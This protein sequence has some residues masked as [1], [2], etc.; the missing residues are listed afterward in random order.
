[1]RRLFYMCCILSLLRGV[2]SLYAQDR[3]TVPVTIIL[4]APENTGF[5]P[6]TAPP[7]LVVAPTKLIILTESNG[8]GGRAVFGVSLSTEPI[9][10][11]NVIFRITSPSGRGTN[12]LRVDNTAPLTFTRMDY[13]QRDVYL[14]AIEH[15]EVGDYIVELIPSGNEAMD[16]KNCYRHSEE[17]Y[18]RY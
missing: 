14:T 10:P 4:E 15:A 5:S 2:E 9:G 11:V 8:G 18:S 12:D 3:T 6:E 1:M 16:I 17:R 13:S 7:T